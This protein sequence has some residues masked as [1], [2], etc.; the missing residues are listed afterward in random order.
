MTPD[1]SAKSRDI[2]KDETTFEAIQQIITDEIQPREQEI[3]QAHFQLNRQKALFDTITRLRDLLD[4]ETIFQSTA[5]EVR[6]LL[7]AD[8]VG[9]FRFYPDFN[10]ND[11][12]LVSEDVDR[13]FPSAMSQK[14]HDHCFG[15]R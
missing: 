2:C 8:R 10:W 14:I 3:S 6:Q 13:D 1:R 5:I 4:L 7:A 15:D 11:G 12:E 9:M